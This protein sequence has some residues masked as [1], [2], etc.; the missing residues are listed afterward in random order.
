MLAFEW[1]ERALKERVNSKCFCWFSAAIFW[2]LRFRDLGASCF[3]LCFR[4]LRFRNYPYFA[5]IWRLHTNLYKGAWN[6][7]ANNSET[8]SQE[9]LRL[10]QIVYILVYFIF[11]ASSTGRFPIFFCCVTVKTIYWCAHDGL[12]DCGGGFIHVVVVYANEMSLFICNI[13][14]YIQSTMNS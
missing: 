10:V 1:K 9:D 12:V 7:S 11:L 13:E 8:V 2:V 3:G 14:F 6:V 4:V 5:P